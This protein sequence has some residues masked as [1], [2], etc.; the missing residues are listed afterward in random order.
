VAE[1]KDRKKAV[2]AKLE[3][4]R[5]ALSTL[6]AKA[7]EINRQ[8]AELLKEKTCYDAL[9]DVISTLDHLTEIG[10]SKLFWGESDHQQN[11]GVHLARVHERVALFDNELKALQQELLKYRREILAT[12][13]KIDNYDELTLV[14]IE[15]EKESLD[16]YV[17]ERE[18][19]GFY[20]RS[21]TMPWTVH[22]EDEKRYRK[23]LLLVLFIALLLGYLAPMWQIPVVDEEVKIEIPE[24]L[25][26]LM[27]EKKLPPPA[28]PPKEEE[29][30]EEKKEEVP[31]E[32]KKDV[33]KE[34][35][36]KPEPTKKET[37]VVRKKVESSGVLAF[38][39]DFAGL[40]DLDSAV[41]AKLGADASLTNKGATAK[42]SSRS[43]ITAQAGSGTGGINTAAL[44]KNVSG[45]GNTIEGVGFSRVESSIGT[46]Y[47]TEDR[48]LSEG[49][50]PSRTDEEIQIVFDKY[51]SALYR[52]Y[53][54]ELRK[55]PTL[56]GKM[57][58][59]LTIEPDGKV[60]ACSIDSSD[61]G[62]P[63]LDENIVARVRRFNF[64]AKEDVPTITILFPVDFLPAN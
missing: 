3:R 43:I 61:M 58:L 35:E 32:E 52:I 56:Q 59:R 18:E 53:N 47:A 16:E 31:K 17:I 41:D 62:A 45:T 55:D 48:P 50:G 2:K 44:S 25:A 46:E 40:L 9:N 29:V 14:L 30:K 19:E 22:G 49:P 20:Y 23:I 4:Y 21:P 57:V 63:S 27:L 36:K 28:P 6:E 12:Q 54:R 51:K 11:A 37:V 33:E 39:S 26:K 15:R 10:G 60:S 5:Q 8:L 38:K 34:V 42:T 13:G 7:R 1:I 64:G 24:R